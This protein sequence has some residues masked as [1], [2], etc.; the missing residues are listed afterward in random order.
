MAS[1]TLYIAAI[2]VAAAAI[3]PVQPPH[4]APPHATPPLGRSCRVAVIGAGIGGASLSFYLQRFGANA[5][6]P[7]CEITA[8]ERNDYIGG[9]LKHVTGFGDTSVVELG[10]WML[11]QCSSLYS[12]QSKARR[13]SEQYT[14]LLKWAQQPS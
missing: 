11:V 14:R 6:L 1:T 9:R 10:E 8:Y 4:V 3:P 12:T 7:R 5:S 2:S 13:D